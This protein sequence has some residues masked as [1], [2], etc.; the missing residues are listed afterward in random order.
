MYLGSSESAHTFGRGVER[1]VRM[2]ELWVSDGNW[3]LSDEHAFH[4]ARNITEDV[5]QFMKIKWSNKDK[6]Y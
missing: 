1:K 5:G 3:T 4:Y 2:V 6:K